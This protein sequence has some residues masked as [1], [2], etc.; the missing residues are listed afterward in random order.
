MP[1]TNKHQLPPE[2]V[3]ALT[4]NRYS[5]DS[6][7]Q[8]FDYSAS[9][10]VAPVQQ[11]I[12][13]KRYPDSGDG[14]VIDKLWSM[15]GSI[16]HELLEEHGSEESLVE[17]R[18]YCTVLGKVLSGQIDHYKS[19]EI[20]DY[21]TTSAYKV[22]TGS[23]DEWE[24][25]LNI[26][27]Y[28]CRQQGLE[29]ESIRIIAILRDWSETDSLKDREY[30]RSP[31]MII[32]IS[33]WAEHK[34]AIY[35]AE[36]IKLLKDNELLEDAKLAPCSLE[37]CWCEEDTWAVYKTLD[38]KRA[39][40]VFKTEQEAIDF[41]NGIIVKRQGKRRR[42]ERYCEVNK[43]CFQFTEYQKEKG[44]INGNSDSTPVIF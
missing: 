1:Y 20:T 28:I 12:L 9:N 2:V 14:D 26:Y 35:L 7:E 33:L 23:Y 31:I 22:K 43:M 38:S 40:R 4:K 39:L 36:R 15:F 6:C 18:F 37:E 5:G 3:A 11:T 44:L 16:A 8:K 24:K 32:P 27:A 30:P 29:V 17:N 10:L 41:N 19:K 34:Q 42:C 21:K 25:Q 13:K